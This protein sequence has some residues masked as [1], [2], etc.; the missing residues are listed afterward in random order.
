[1]N[2]LRFVEDLIRLIVLGFLDFRR[3]GVRVVLFFAFAAELMV[4]VI[5]ADPTFPLWGGAVV[6]FVQRVFGSYYLHYPESFIGLPVTGA[7]GKLL[8]DLFVSPFV[9]AWCGLAVYHVVGDERTQNKTPARDSAHYY[10]PLFLLTCVEIAGWILLYGLPIYLLNTRFDLSYRIHSLITTFGSLLPLLLLCP[11]FFVPAHLLR[12]D[13]GLPRAIGASFRRTRQ[14]LQWPVAFVLL[15]WLAGLPLALI[16]QRSTRLAA[17]LR[18]EI[19][20]VVVAL[21]A[22]IFLLF[23]FLALDASIRIFLKPRSRGL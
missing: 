23:G 9:A 21:Q 13:R 20:L 4:F 10:L 5:C 3:A 17:Q 18:P 22:A 15:P 12:E 19:V 14:D 11:L 7:A 8:V 6:P 2:L 16:L 1:M